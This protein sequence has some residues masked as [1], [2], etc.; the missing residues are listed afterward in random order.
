MVRLMV[1]F[2]IMMHFR[3]YSVY[4]NSGICSKFLSQCVFSLCDNETLLCGVLGYYRSN[5]NG[6]MIENWIVIVINLQMAAE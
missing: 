2:S 1:L 4:S 5:A 6:A 3:K